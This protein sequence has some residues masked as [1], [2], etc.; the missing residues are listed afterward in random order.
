FE[1]ILLVRD[2]GVEFLSALSPE[3]LPIIKSAAA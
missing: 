1:E 3:Q 2:E